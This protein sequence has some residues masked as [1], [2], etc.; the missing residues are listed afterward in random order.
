MRKLT[1]AVALCSLLAGGVACAQWRLIA[2]GSRA[3]YG[4]TRADGGRAPDLARV[5]LAA[6][7]NL[8]VRPMQLG[9]GCVGFVM[10]RPDHILDYANPAPRLRFV[11]RVTNGDA[12]LVVHTPDGRWLC[13]D[14]S[15]HGNDAM[16][17]LNSP[18]AGRYD[19]WV[20]SYRVDETPP[21][22]LSISA[23][24]PSA[25]PSGPGR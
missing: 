16:L 12:T 1:A 3:N 8:D 13:D 14:D 19:I 24:E 2:G 5:D 11:V 20:G 18:P 6:G 4:I 17:L 23:P 10:A 9:E 22:T 21:A 7:G 25:D 15:G